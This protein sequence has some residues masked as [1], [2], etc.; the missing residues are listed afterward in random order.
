[1]TL[2]VAEVVQTYTK[3]THRAHPSIPSVKIYPLKYIKE[4]T[5][6]KRNPAFLPLNSGPCAVNKSLNLETCPGLTQ[7]QIGFYPV[8]EGTS[9]GPS[10][11]QMGTV[12]THA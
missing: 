6:G 8:Q 4:Y 11:A 2:D 1:M 9:P 7:K 3:Q 5:P 12:D 10:L